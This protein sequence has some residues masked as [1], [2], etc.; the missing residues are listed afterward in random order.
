MYS[1][2]QKMIHRELFIKTLIVQ[3]EKYDIY[4]KHRYS[5][6][7]MR[8]YMHACTIVTFFKPQENILLIVDPT[9]K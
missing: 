3:I 4:I 2:Y 8:K 1:P 9:K 7:R 6:I 5:S